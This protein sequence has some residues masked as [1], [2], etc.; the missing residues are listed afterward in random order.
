M[1]ELNRSSCRKC[2]AVC[3]CRSKKH[4]HKFLGGHWPNCE[5]A[6]DPSLIEWKNLGVG[7]FSRFVRQVIVYSLSAVII[8]VCFSGIVYAMDYSDDMKES[9]WK[10]S[11][12]GAFSYSKEEAFLDQL[13]QQTE[14]QGILECYC[15]EQFKTVG[16]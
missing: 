11:E 12:C 16:I 8:F 15:Y 6:P 5:T 7:G 3:C 13:K 4:V 9:A 2:C 14:R 1:Q 10:E